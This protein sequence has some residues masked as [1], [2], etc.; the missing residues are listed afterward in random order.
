MTDPYR[1][2]MLAHCLALAAIGEP[3]AI[4]AAGWYERNEPQI[5]QNLQAKVR[6]ELARAAKGST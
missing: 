2:R 4:E 6:Q 3:N 1:T 5:L